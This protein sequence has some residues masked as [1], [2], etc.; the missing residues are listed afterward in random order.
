MTIKLDKR[1]FYK[2]LIC[3]LLLIPYIRP[4][5]IDYIGGRIYQIYVLALYASIIIIYIWYLLFRRKFSTFI[6]IVSA[7]EG[8]LM[9]ATYRNHGIRISAIIEFLTYTSICMLVELLLDEGGLFC[10][11]IFS[12][13]LDI[14]ILLNFLTII[15]YP[16]G[17]YT[18]ISNQLYKN[19]FLG[20]AN[21]HVQLILAACFFSMAS[22]ILKYGKFKISVHNL[23]IFLFGIISVI[24][25]GKATPFIVLSV[26][27]IYF[28]FSRQLEISRFMNGYTVIVTNLV[29]FIG[30]AVLNI[31][32]RFANLIISVLHRDLTFTGRTPLW[33]LALVAIN[34]RPRIGHGIERLSIFAQKFNLNTCHNNYLWV[35]YR[36]GIIGF[37][38]LL[39]ILF[40]VALKLSKEKNRVFTTFCSIILL[41]IMLIWQ[42]ESMNGVIFFAIYSIM[43]HCERLQINSNR[44]IAEIKN[45]KYRVKF[46]L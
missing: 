22:S 19:W 36:T 31:Q 23:F 4:P 7:Y 41:C 15:L 33:N 35:M 38:L 18:T 3:M 24:M 13:V 20:L 34:D 42:S 29:L 5:Y 11:S 21:L 46:H 44:H 37:V 43:Y 2:R 25:T 9:L 12:I 40:N 30:I 10:T 1:L 14:L 17:L 32:E 28:I 27:M 26:I 6:F 8:I 45:E 16:D 39:I